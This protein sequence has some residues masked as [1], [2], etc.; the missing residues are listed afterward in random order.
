M[1]LV[2]LFIALIVPNVPSALAQIEQGVVPVA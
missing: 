2:S 1:L